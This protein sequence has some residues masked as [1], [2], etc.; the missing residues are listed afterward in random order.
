MRRTVYGCDCQLMA[1]MST[2]IV[3]ELDEAGDSPVGNACLADGTCRPFHG[4]LA[5]AEVID[6]LAGMSTRGEA[7]SNVSGASSLRAAGGNRAERSSS[8]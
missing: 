7:T 2:T 5:L 1:R 3:L 6:S 4:W 8:S